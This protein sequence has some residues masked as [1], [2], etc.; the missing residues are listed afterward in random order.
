MDEIFLTPPSMEYAEDIE[1]YK[2]E[3]VDNDEDM[4]GSAGLRLMPTVKEWLAYIDK[5]SREETVRPGLAPSTVFLIVRKSD[6]RVVGM[7]D[8]RHKLTPN[9]YFKGGHIGYGVRKSERRK[10]YAKEAL[11]LALKECRKLG[12]NRALVICKKENAASAN[13]IIASGGILS[14]EA[15][16]GFGGVIC[17]YWIV[18]PDSEV[19]LSGER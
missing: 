8:I 13:T 16:D 4:A 17:R 15:P 14:D 12:I 18:V 2:K 6:N 11:R 10:G 1:L 7:I 5:N 3:F 9:L 19:V